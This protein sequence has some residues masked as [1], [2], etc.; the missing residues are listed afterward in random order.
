[1]FALLIMMGYWMFFG[2]KAAEQMQQQ[3]QNEQT[4]QQ[5]Q[6]LE[7]IEIKP[8]KARNEVINEGQRIVIDTESLSGSFL[9]QGSRFDD[10]SLKNYQKTI[11]EDSPDVT[12][13]TPE[14]AEQAAYIFWMPVAVLI[15]TGL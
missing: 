4:F 2:K 1:M 9:V 5:E 15:Q 3:A 11:A 7:P 13:L 8:L 6:R 14:G 12:L 10:I